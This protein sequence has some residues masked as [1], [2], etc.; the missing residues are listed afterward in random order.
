MHTTRADFS[1]LADWTVSND[2]GSFSHFDHNYHLQNM[3]LIKSSWDKLSDILKIPEFAISDP[4]MQNVEDPADF[5]WEI[6]ESGN[7]RKETHFTFYGLV[8]AFILISLLVC[9]FHSE[10]RKICQCL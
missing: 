5:S 6:D 8:I 1:T 7:I 9:C 10:I 2:L 3:H 4:D